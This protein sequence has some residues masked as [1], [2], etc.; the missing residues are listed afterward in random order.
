MR[1]YINLHLTVLLDPIMM[2][3]IRELWN[4]CMFNHV[5]S[6]EIYEEWESYVQWIVKQQSAAG[7]CVNR[8]ERTEE[9]GAEYL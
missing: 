9:L 5:V 3:L 4:L 7:C 6:D 8:G 1:E 2:V